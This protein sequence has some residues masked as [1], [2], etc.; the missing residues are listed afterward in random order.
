[1]PNSTHDLVVDF[2]QD[3]QSTKTFIKQLID[4]VHKEEKQKLR[5]TTYSDASTSQQENMH[6]STAYFRATRSHAKT[7]LSMTP[8]GFPSDWVRACRNKPNTF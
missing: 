7:A 2:P 3:P 6:Q 1:M 8:A 4:T 5:R